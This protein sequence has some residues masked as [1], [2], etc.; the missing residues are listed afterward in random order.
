LVNHLRAKRRKIKRRRKTSRSRNK[1][2][3]R[4]AKKKLKTRKRTRRRASLPRNLQ[5]IHW[6]WQKN[7]LKEVDPLLRRF[8]S[9]KR[10]QLHQRDKLQ[11]PLWSLKKIMN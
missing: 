9:V 4:R 8:I 10:R 2:R 6:L 11:K 7:K 5:S 3:K 1:R